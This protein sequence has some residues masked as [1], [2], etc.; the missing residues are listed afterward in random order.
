MSRP[1]TGIGFADRGGVYT[2]VRR[3]D[4]TR[5][6]RRV[7]EVTPDGPNTV[8]WAKSVSLQLQARYDREAWDP[9][10]PPT[11][12]PST[13]AETETM[14][15]WCTRWLAARRAAGL[16]SVNDDRGRLEHHVLAVIGDEP[17][18]TVTRERIED[19]RDALD[20]KV[21]SGALAGATGTKVWGLVTKLFSDARRAKDRALRV[22]TDNP[23][24]DVAP[25]DRVPERDG[26]VL[27]PGELLAL[28]A[29]PR[30]PL[31]WR[32]LFALAVY[33]CARRAELAA[34]E[35]GSIDLVR[36]TLHL[37]QTTDRKGRVLKRLKTKTS[38]RVA[39]EPAL[40]P[41]VAALVREAGGVGRVVRMPPAEDMAEYLRACLGYA[42]V[43]RSELFA[44]DATRRPITFHDLRATGLT[45][46]AIRGD[47]AL[48]IQERA[49]HTTFATTQGYVRLAE[50][51]GDVG[52]VFPPLPA[53]LVGGF[54]GSSVSTPTPPNE[55]SPESAGIPGLHVATPTGLEPERDAA[56][57]ATTAETGG[58]HA[59]SGTLAAGSVGD[60]VGTLTVLDRLAPLPFSDLVYLALAVENGTVGLG[61]GGDA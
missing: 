27:Y 48:R 11:T 19:L 41:L 18:A 9:D 52:A 42:G 57:R 7:A 10:A 37:H 15:D 13:V 28:V 24:A 54:V 58:P 60:S 1:R 49:G 53:E 56:I 5:W 55:Q 12:G 47:D 32:R 21:R 33:T 3:R 45:W 38:R 6:T 44:D 8:A 31:R 26:P 17:I 16:A 46:M 59:R 14:R 39:L 30:V 36:N 51:L 4:G 22:R 35:C 34:L 23:T 61:P 2:G 50:T 25:P 29:C 20:T 40:R 43:T